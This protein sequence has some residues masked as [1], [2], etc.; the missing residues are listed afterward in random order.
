MFDYE[1]D[2]ATQ[3]KRTPDAVYKQKSM[4]GFR[5]GPHLAHDVRELALH[6]EHLSLQSRVLPLER[7]QGGAPC[8]RLALFCLRKRRKVNAS[9]G[10]KARSERAPREQL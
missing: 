3:A 1:H 5:R 9:Y 10:S 4:R 8:P 6:F 2:Y 7:V